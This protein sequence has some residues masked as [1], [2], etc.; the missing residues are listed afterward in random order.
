MSCPNQN[1]GGGVQKSS[2]LGI[3]KPHQN[4]QKI[5]CVQRKSCNISHI[6]DNDQN[7]STFEPSRS[8]SMNLN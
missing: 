2:K 7:I 5:D 1:N 4:L 8:T 3:G 6:E